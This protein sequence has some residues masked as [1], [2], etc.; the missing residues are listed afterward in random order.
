MPEWPPFSSD[1]FLQA[2]ADWYFPGAKPEVVECE[3]KRYRTL[4]HGWRKRPVSGFYHFPFYLEP[5]PPELA[6]DRAR[7]V[8]FLADVVVAVTR[9]GE[10]GPP[11]AAPSPFVRLTEFDSWEQALKGATPRPGLNSPRRIREKMNRVRREFGGIEV[12]TQDSDVEAF[13][14]VI[15]WKAA[16]YSR[17]SSTHRMTLEHNQ[18]FYRELWRRGFFTFTTLR[19]GGRLAAGKIGGVGSGRSLWRITVYDPDLSVH[20]PGSIIEMESL[21]AE[22]EAGNIESDYLMGDEPYKFTFATHVRWI[23]KVGREPRLDRLLRLIRRW[24]GRR[25][26]RTPGLYRLAKRIEALPAVLRRRVSRR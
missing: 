15:R 21:R 20:S 12:R 4:V 14:Q 13:E 10:P 1:L 8:P 6:A 7:K 5:L 16:Q 23:G 19:F 2:L 18:E 22:L 3:G 26:R 11:H 9:P 17:S 25:A 24:A